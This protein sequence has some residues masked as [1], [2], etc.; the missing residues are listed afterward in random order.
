MDERLVQDFL[1]LFCLSICDTHNVS[2][3][4]STKPLS[5]TCHLF[6]LSFGRETSILVSF[7]ISEAL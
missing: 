4:Q 6:I 3:L 1:L 5:L 2:T 7:S